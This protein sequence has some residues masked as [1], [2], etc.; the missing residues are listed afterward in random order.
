MRIIGLLLAATFGTFVY[1]ALKGSNN[2]FLEWDWK[3]M[4]VLAAVFCAAQLLC[5][6][7]KP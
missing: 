1:I 3:M 7:D 2:P 4:G 6:E 5:R